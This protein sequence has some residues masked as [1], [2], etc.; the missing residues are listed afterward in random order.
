MNEADDGTKSMI[1]YCISSENFS[2]VTSKSKH[3]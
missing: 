2:E 3:S 1:F